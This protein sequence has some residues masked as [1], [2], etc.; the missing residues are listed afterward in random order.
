MGNLSFKTISTYTT[1]I[2]SYTMER[3]AM[4]LKSPVIQIS[5]NMA[6][7]AVCARGK[8]QFDVSFMY[9]TM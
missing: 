8:L 9:F 2:T 3:E 7:N 1:L 5:T 6:E 4:P